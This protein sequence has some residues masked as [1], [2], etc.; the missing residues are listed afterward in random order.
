MEGMGEGKKERWKNGRR[1]RGI[2]V[3]RNGRD[4][5]DDCGECGAC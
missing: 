2:N 3:V 1:V 4:G 5:M